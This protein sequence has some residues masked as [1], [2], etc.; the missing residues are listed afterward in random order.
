MRPITTLCILAAIKFCEILSPQPFINFKSKFYIYALTTPY[1][2]RAKFC[3][4][5]FYLVEF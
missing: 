4:M 5:K 2:S 3:H 1:F